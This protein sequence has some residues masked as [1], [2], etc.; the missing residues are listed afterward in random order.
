[1]DNQTQETQKRDQ[2]KQR[3]E[4]LAK[5][6]ENGF[7]YPNDLSPSHHTSQISTNEVYNS[8][9]QEKLL[10]DKT[11]VSIA[12]RMMTRRLMGKASFFNIQDVSGQIQVYARANDLP[13]DMYEK[14]V[15]YDI[16]DILFVKG[17]VFKTKVGEISVY[18]TQVTILSK[19][20]HPLPDKYHGL[21][22]VEICYRQRYLD[23]MVNKE[24]KNRF[25]TRS[26]VIQQLRQYLSDQQFMEV[27]TPMMHA[28]ASGANAKPFHT[29]HNALDMPLFLRVAPELHLKRLLVGGMDRVFEVNRNFR[30][31]GLSTRHNPEFTMV[32]FYQAYADYHMMM[33]LT[34]SL[35]RALVIGVKSDQIIPYQEQEL[36]FSTA[37][38][39]MKM[40]DAIA[41]F[42]DDISI[43]A[44]HSL[45]SLRAVVD[46]KN[47]VVTNGATIGVLQLALFEELVEEKLITPIFITHYPKDVSP[48][49]RA[50]DHDPEVTDRF[51]LFIAGKEIANG[52]SELND[53]EDQAERFTKQQE[54]KLD[55]DEEAMDFDTDYICALEYALP[56]AGGVGIG[57][58]RLVML[59][60]NAPSIRDVILFP[61][62]RKKQEAS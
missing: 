34:E 30:N 5:L 11:D 17:Y 10:E 58:D 31:E 26:R 33:D 6:R 40:V 53:P 25:I 16:G 1:M 38:A 59:L 60:T 49:A 4:K 27:E 21:H 23:I 46:Q 45:E 42:N 61:L 37:F 55:G 2:V 47:I 39:R 57:I 18:A 8:S 43:E 7:K 19:S 52:F 29:H 22:D 62:M 51:E 13:E 44:L 14:F 56:P 9:T 41:H 36:D 28:L 48:L 20:L 54:A 15:D 12:G 32:E 3:R 50:S 35:I 24:S